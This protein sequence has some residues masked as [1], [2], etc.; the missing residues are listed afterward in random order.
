LLQYLQT[1]DKNIKD[2]INN[3][4]DIGEKW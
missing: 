4:V 3:L 1:L 2:T